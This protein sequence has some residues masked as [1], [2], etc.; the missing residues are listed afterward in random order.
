MKRATVA[1]VFPPIKLPTKM[2]RMLNIAKN[3]KVFKTFHI[4]SF[5]PPI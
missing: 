3:K 4:N 5:S 2:K 1:P